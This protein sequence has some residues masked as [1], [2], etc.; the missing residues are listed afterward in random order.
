MHALFH[1]SPYF[2][3]GTR[4]FTTISSFLTWSAHK[5]SSSKCFFTRPFQIYCNLTDQVSTR[6]YLLCLQL[7]HP[8]SEYRN[9]SECTSKTC[10]WFGFQVFLAVLCWSLT[11]LTQILCR[12]QWSWNPLPGTIIHAWLRDLA[13]WCIVI[14]FAYGFWFL[15]SQLWTSSYFQTLKPF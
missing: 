11:I 2:L 14:W 10:S 7:L 5:W 4:N 1:F 6:W 13:Y 15:G 3:I 8:W 12:A 9:F